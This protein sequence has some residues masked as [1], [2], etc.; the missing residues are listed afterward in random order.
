M[1]SNGLNGTLLPPPEKH[2]TLVTLAMT[3]NVPT[4]RR[5]FDF[6]SDALFRP[7]DLF[8]F[9]FLFLGKRSFTICYVC[10]YV[11]YFGM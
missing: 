2:F 9:L 4:G 10:N 6:L 7:F 5:M 11:Y 8:F 3:R 1:W